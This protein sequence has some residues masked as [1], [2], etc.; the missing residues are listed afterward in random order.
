MIKFSIG[1]ISKCNHLTKM[2]R[3]YSHNFILFNLNRISKYYY[4]NIESKI[5]NFFQML[6]IRYPHRIILRC[7]QLTDKELYGDGSM[8]I[9]KLLTTSHC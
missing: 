5:R 8:N 7:N 1:I 6:I 9:I 4:I 3:K 2:I